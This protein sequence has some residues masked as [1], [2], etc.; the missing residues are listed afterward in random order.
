MAEYKYVAELYFEAS[1]MND[2]HAKLAEHYR[3]LSVGE[4]SFLA[5]EGSLS[6]IGEPEFDQS[7]EKIGIVNLNVVDDAT[8]ASKGGEAV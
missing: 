6:A 2:A 8:T 1:D 4:P 7:I 5:K 3:K